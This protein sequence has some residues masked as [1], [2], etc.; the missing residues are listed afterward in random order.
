M[1][2]DLDQPD[3]PQSS[4]TIVHGLL[5]VLLL[6]VIGIVLVPYLIPRRR[7]PGYESE[8]IRALKTIATAQAIYREGDKEQDGN[9]DYGMLS[10]LGAPNFEL[11]DSVLAKGTKGGY[12]FQASY[13]FLTSDF[14]WFA[15][16]NPV[17]PGRTGDRYFCTNHA[18]VIFYTT[19]GSLALDTDT[20]YLPARGVLPIGK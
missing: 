14:L 13:S 3:R 10:E 1:S 19:G 5:I 20:C 4:F 7:P 9:L 16:A 15:V 11:V 18:G 17:T 2:Q 8:A 12:L 6:V